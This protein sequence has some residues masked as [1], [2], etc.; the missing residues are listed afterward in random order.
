ML[1]YTYLLIIAIPF[2]SAALVPL[3]GHFFPRAR[4]WFAVACAVLNALI[5]ISIIP[6]V[7]NIINA[8]VPGYTILW[9]DAI[10]L[11]VTF[12]I[13]ALG[14]LLA[15]IAAI[16]GLLVVVYSVKYMEADEKKYN[17]SRYYSL[18]LLFIGA[19]VCL[20]L[21]DNL[22]IL[23]F[24]W[25]IVGLCSY[26]LIG[27]YHDDPKA[28]KAGMKA[29]VT[30]RVGDAFLLIGIIVLYWQTKSFSI[31]EI[32]SAVDIGSISV[33]SLALPGACFILGAIGKSAQVPLHVWLPDAMEAPTPISA[34]IHA[35]TMV[36]AGIYLI[37]RV[38]PIFSEVQYWLLAIGIIGAVTMLITAIQA[39]VEIDLK[40]LLA[41]STISQLAYLML[42]ASFGVTYGLFSS[43]FH[44]LV[45][46]TFKALLFLCA[47]AIIHSVGSKSMMDMGGLKNKMRYTFLM[48]MFGA[49]ALA[50]IP[51]FGGFWSKDLIFASALKTSHY[52][53]F[54]VAAF[55]ALL[56]I[57]YTLRMIYL[58]FY[59]KRDDEV[60]AHDPSIIM[61]IPLFILGIGALTLG[62]LENSLHTLFERGMILPLDM[63]VGIV[64]EL[65][66][67]IFS[68]GTSI[69]II[70]IGFLIFR[71]YVRNRDK[72]IASS[73]SGVTS[74]LYNIATNGFYFDRFYLWLIGGLL[75]M[76]RV[77]YH[78]FDIGATDKFCYE[79]VAGGTINLGQKFR[80]VQTGDLNYN[81]VGI[82][83]GAILV[84]ILI[85][86]GGV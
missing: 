16:I 49:F 86:I 10:G 51:P 21:T 20:V 3:V 8:G 82:V 65:E 61:L 84:T 54:I 19:M 56:T 27:Y 11:N 63:H 14:L 41:Y 29:F 73:K 32:I 78:K 75:A 43:S 72:L 59:R 30:T 58:V 7:W 71:Y 22:L 35:A 52:L 50:S 48:T 80:H 42:A 44:L 36:N 83:I 39:L 25:E 79:T 69:A 47:G 26:A 33:S 62:F 67:I 85:F 4:A 1:P 28:A 60:K 55:T 12:Y 15:L 66:Y 76:G 13:D 23:Y 68:V 81:M 45:H 31:Q 74:S 37:L 5:I 53:F 6:D 38:M 77:V 40:R 24:F 9:N 46:G 70:V 2:I 64:K 17:L 34:L 18:V 57:L